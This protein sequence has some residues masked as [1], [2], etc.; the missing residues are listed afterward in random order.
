[1]YSQIRL[2]WHTAVGHDVF[3]QLVS[4]L[5][6]RL[7]G[8]HSTPLIRQSYQILFILYFVLICFSQRWVN[9]INA[10]SYVSSTSK[11]CTFFNFSIS[12][13]FD[14]QVHLFLYMSSEPLC[15]RQIAHFSDSFLQIISQ[16]LK[17]SGKRIL[18]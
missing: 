1:M 8:F 9:F 16:N 6:V 15:I 11:S 14:S 7:I 18:P 4:R 3:L 12:V 13:C 10:S 17:I 2:S 5:D